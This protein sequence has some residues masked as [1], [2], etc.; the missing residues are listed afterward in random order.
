[1]RDQTR[2]RRN[3]LRHRPAFA[4]RGAI[5]VAI[6]A[7]LLAAACS[8]GSG[9]SAAPTGTAS[10]IAQKVFDEA[11]VEAF[12]DTQTLDTP[13]EISYFLGSTNYPPFSDTAVVQPMISIDARIM[14]VLEVA[15]EQEAADV[16]KQLEADVDPTKLICVV[17]SMDDVVIDS[18]GTVVFMVIDAT[19]AERE[20]LANAF[21]AID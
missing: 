21:T 2:S 18:R 6:I 4:P 10:E 19:P 13:E 3:T 12:G 14:Y 17:F 7:G 1:M 8:S 11:K 16:V 15:T 9:G 20:A 5:A